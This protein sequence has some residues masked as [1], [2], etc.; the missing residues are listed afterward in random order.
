[1]S[2]CWSCLTDRLIAHRQRRVVR[3]QALQRDAPWRQPSRR[4]QRPIGTIRPVSSAIGMNSSGRDEAALGVAPAQQRLDARRREPSCERGR[5]AGS[6]AR[7]GRWRARAG[8]RRAARGGRATPSCIA[9]L[10]QAVA[11][12]A[13]A[14]GDVHRGV[15]VADQLVGVGDGRAGSTSEMPMLAR[16]DELLVPDAQRRGERLEHALGG[17]GGLLRV[18][19]VLEQ[20]RELVAAEARGGV[21]GA[22]ARRPGAWRP[23]AAPRRRRRGRGCR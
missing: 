15:G 19:D 13:V 22:D 3:A 9:R 10:E 20:H 8:G 17:V 18:V 21:A 2:E 11:A 16:S 4:T 23:R 14:L 1:M 6:A 5:P 7:T 12:L